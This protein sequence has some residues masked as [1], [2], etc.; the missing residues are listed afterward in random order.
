MSKTDTAEVLS[1]NGNGGR[2]SIPPWVWAVGVSLLV[3]ILGAAYVT[4]TVTAKLDSLNDRVM[5]LERQ[6][7]EFYSSGRM[8]R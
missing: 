2:L 4:G 1:M 3:Q 6:S 7:D 8:P 5:R